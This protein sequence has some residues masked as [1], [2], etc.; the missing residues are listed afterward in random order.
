[1]RYRCG[2]VRIVS[3]NSHDVLQ[4]HPSRKVYSKTPKG[5]CK[6]RVIGTAK[7][8]KSSKNED[9]QTKNNK[10]LN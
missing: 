5:I 9:L 7:G 3:M 10:L 1:M 4:A 8:V 6:D 2:L